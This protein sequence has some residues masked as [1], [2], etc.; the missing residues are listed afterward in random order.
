V[1]DGARGVHF[2]VTAV[3][4]D[5]EGQWLSGAYTPPE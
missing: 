2:I 3:Q 1:Q 4:S 5:E